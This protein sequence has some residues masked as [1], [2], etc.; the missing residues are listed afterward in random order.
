MTW[1]AFVDES[2]RDGAGLYLLAAACLEGDAVDEARAAV[3]QLARSHRRFHW[4]DE[5][6]ADRA[7]AVGLV[8][9]LPALHMVVVAAPLDPRRQERARRYCLRR[10]L[11]ELDRAGIGPCWME[12]RGQRQ[13]LRDLQ[14]VNVLRIQRLIRPTLTVGHARPVAEPLLWLPDIVAGAIGGELD[15]GEPY[16]AELA[17]VIT[18]YHVDLR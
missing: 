7:K 12:S 17:S 14:T 5:E 18:R 11:F 8:S 10:L 15:R 2:M 3:A 16:A 13:D 9:A 6:P 4:R 1:A